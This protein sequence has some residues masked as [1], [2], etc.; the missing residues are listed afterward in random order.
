MKI[1]ESKSNRKTQLKKRLGGKS[2][3]YL[4]SSMLALHALI[5]DKLGAVSA[6]NKQ[7]DSSFLEFQK[8]L[9]K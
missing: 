2:T 1:R 8:E 4:D 6:Y 5:L 9:H 3:D 7:D